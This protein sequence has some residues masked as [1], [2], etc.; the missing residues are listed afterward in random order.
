MDLSAGLDQS[1]DALGAQNFAHLA[2][3][4]HHS[5]GLQVRPERP[6]G[7]LLR[8]GT[9]ESKGSR[10][11]AMRTLRHLKNPFLLIITYSRSSFPAQS[12]YNDVRFKP[13]NIT[14]KSINWQR[15]VYEAIST[16]I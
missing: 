10:F 2:S 12:S 5:D 4:L 11:S 9:I 3:V 6:R 8:P 13:D 7:G 15:R 1:A 16:H 14:I